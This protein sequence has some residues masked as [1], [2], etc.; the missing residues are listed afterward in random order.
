[1]PTDRFDEPRAF[2]TLERRLI[3][4]RLRDLDA[5]LRVELAAIA[6]LVGGFLFWQIRIPLDGL[7]RQRGPLSAAGAL[8]ALGLLFALSAAVH[9]GTDYAR[10]LRRSPEGPEWLTLPVHPESLARHF[11]WSSRGRALWLSVPL[12]GVLLAG[13]GLIPVLWL[14]ALALACG[15]LLYA[16][17]GVGCAAGL[18]IAA[19]APRRREPMRPLPVPEHPVARLLAGAAPRLRGRRVRAARWRALPAGVALWAKDLRV[20]ARHVGL[21]RGAWVTLA[22]LTASWLA[23]QIPSAPA[24]AHFVALALSLL[25]AAALADWLIALSGSD[26][27]ATLRSL[28]V[29]LAAFWGARFAWAVLGAVALVLGH[30]WA[31]HDLAPHARAVFLIWSAT[32]WLAIATLGVNYGVTL[33]PRAD[34]AQR[35]LGLSLALAVCASLMI[36]LMG[37]I[38]LLTGVIHSCR[39]LPHWAQLE[40]V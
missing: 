8:L 40:E 15:W 22:L 19:R 10:Q 4:R 17:T 1:M 9:A 5:R 12:L 3:R 39:R 2:R 20:N 37:W 31:S 36:P 11:A 18:A 30:V 14:V 27:F 35:L 23:W 32:A 7:A 33:F 24:L 25:A 34:I 16:A 28:P 6:L 21:R 29:G 13:V 26:P 38:V